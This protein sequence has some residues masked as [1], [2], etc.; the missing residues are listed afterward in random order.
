MQLEDLLLRKEELP[1]FR[2]NCFEVPVHP[3]LLD[4]TIDINPRLANE[5]FPK[6]LEPWYLELQEYAKTLTDLPEK[7]WIEEVYLENMP[8]IETEGR[9]QRIKGW[10]DNV[11]SIDN[12]FA[13]YLSISRDAG[14]SLYFSKSECRPLLLK[15]KYI[16]F[17]EEKAKAYSTGSSDKYL[18]GNGYLHHNIDAYPGALFLRNWAI[19]YQN[20]ALKEIFNS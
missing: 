5:L 3:R 17:T 14:G 1:I 20:E 12:G 7:N 13:S 18:F 16:R 2:K 19:M 4:P 10:E 8:K 15:S 9:R 6:V 11:N